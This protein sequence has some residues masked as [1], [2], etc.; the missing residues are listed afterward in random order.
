MPRRIRKPP[1]DASPTVL[2]F[3]FSERNV[4]ADLPNQ[5]WAHPRDAPR[6]E[7]ASDPLRARHHVS[8]DR[9]G[10]FARHRL[11]WENGVSELNPKST[12]GLALRSQSS[13]HVLLPGFLS[14][15]RLPP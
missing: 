10:R 6:L 8:S 4:L 9:A 11:L 14:P 5:L 15:E 12:R 13:G 7:P 2:R 3:P 1:H